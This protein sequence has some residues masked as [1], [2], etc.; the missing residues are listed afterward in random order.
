[1]YLPPFIE[2]NSDGFYFCSFED[3]AKPRFMTQESKSSDRKLISFAFLRMF[4]LT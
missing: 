4:F 1:M 3:L 2:V